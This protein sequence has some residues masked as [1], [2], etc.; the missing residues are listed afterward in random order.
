MNDFNMTKTLPLQLQEHVCDILNGIPELSS[1]GAV[2][3]PEDNLD[4]D[5]QIQKAIG[6]QGLVC[7]VMTPLFNYQ[8]HNGL[9]QTYTADDLTI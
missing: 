7:V 2:F 4:I 5:F 1:V 9:T 3:L 6:K 8:G